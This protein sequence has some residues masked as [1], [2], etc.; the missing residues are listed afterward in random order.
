[1]GGWANKLAGAAARIAG[2]LHVV[3]AVSRGDR[4]PWQYPIDGPTAEAAVRL[5]RDYL[6]PHAKAAFGL[7]E[8]DPAAENAKRILGWLK[9]RSVT[10]VTSVRHSENQRSET[11]IV[12]RRDIQRAL[13]RQ[14]PAA[15]GMD[16]AVRILME[17][18]WLQPT[19]DGRAGRGH[20]SPT[21]FVYPAVRELA[22]K[23]NTQDTGD[24]GDNRKRR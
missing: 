6:L 19:G 15:D 10:S 3:K 11:L 2:I 23:S 12:S 17:H 5:A 8:A 4:N 1:M 14:F 13:H 20:A 7:M 21:Y 18:G 16:P 9:V 22:A 24:T